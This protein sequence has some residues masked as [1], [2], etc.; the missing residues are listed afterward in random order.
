MAGKTQ[1]DTN[2]THVYL[3]CGKSQDQKPTR[4]IIE[5]TKLIIESIDSSSDDSNQN[6]LEAIDFEFIYS[7]DHHGDK[8]DIHTATIQ[9]LQTE[10]TK[11]NENQ[12][13]TNIRPKEAK[14]ILNTLH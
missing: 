6:H 14:W 13:L 10:S 8:L 12:T 4:L 2:P 9:D 5:N 1:L 7:I 11:D 3:Y